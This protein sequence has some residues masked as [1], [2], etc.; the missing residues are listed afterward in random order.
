M[1]IGHLTCLGINLK[2]V[3]LNLQPFGLQPGI[4]L[5]FLNGSIHFLFDRLYA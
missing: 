2:V 5:I 1:Q 3:L 4:K